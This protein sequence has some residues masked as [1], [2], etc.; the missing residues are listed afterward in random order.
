MWD[1]LVWK[2]KVKHL[3]NIFCCCLC[4]KVIT[5]WS[6]WVKQKV[7]KWICSFVFL[8]WLLNVEACVPF[9]LDIASLDVGFVPT[10]GLGGGRLV[11]TELSVPRWVGLA[12]SSK[13]QHS[14]RKSLGRPLQVDSM[15]P[16]WEF[17]P[18]SVEAWV[19]TS[20]PGPWKQ[21]CFRGCAESSLSVP[22]SPLETTQSE[23]VNFILKC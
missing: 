4:I 20:V 7:L 19:S 12:S 5:F 15:R 17:Y 14:F 3:T 8:S 16:T 11:L 23:Q 18:D 21:R 10:M 6:Y 1:A 22:P 9:L 13:Y 2:Q